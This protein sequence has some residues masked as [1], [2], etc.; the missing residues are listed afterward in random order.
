MG[1][2][3]NRYVC[4]VVLAIAALAPLCLAQKTYGKFEVWSVSQGAT[5]CA[6]APVV[7]YLQTNPAKCGTL[8]TTMGNTFYFLEGT[9]LNDMTF[10][11]CTDSACSQCNA[12]SPIA[13]NTCIDETTLNGNVTQ[14]DFL[15][16]TDVVDE[17]KLDNIL[18]PIPYSVSYEAPSPGN[19]DESSITGKAPFDCIYISDLGVDYT[20]QCANNK[21]Q[22]Q[23]CTTSDRTCGGCSGDFI[24][25]DDLNVGTCITDS[26]LYGFTNTFQ[27]FCPAS[28]SPS[29]SPLSFATTIVIALLLSLLTQV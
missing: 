12:A 11:T 29:L 18:G 17:A 6:G 1:L 28:W 25:L 26:T 24:P 15:R 23:R 9:T 13:P 19:C 16:L 7:V 10:K 4:F 27:Y 8:N 14:P 20:V 2:T 22:I 21:F 3:V 5:S